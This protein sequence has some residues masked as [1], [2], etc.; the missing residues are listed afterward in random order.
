MAI[1]SEDVIIHAI[2]HQ[3]R[4]EIL[5][6]LKMGTKTFSDLLNHFDISTGKLNYH[7]TQIKGFIRKD[8]EGK[9]E[10]TSLGLRALEILAKIREEIYLHLDGLKNDLLEYFKK[11]PPQKV[12]ISPRKKKSYL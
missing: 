11:S 5:E 7:L 1:P 4:R 10:L 8:E 6:I 9:Y 12:D 3:I 2:S